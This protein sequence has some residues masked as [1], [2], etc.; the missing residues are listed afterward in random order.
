MARACAQQ[1]FVTSKSANSAT[2]LLERLL[3]KFRPR[4]ASYRAPYQ[5][6]VTSRARTVKCC[7]IEG[8]SFCRTSSG[9]LEIAS[10]SSRSGRFCRASKMTGGHLVVPKKSQVDTLVPHRCRIPAECPPPSCTASAGCCQ[11]AKATAMLAKHWG[12]KS[13]AKQ[14]KKT[15]TLTNI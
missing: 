9:C 8:P 11:G 13:C 7:K 6:S 5:T 10:K 3:Q 15:R 1:R 2:K 4:I 12:V 14:V